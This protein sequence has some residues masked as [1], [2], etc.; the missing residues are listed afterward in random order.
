MRATH[1]VNVIDYENTPATVTISAGDQVRWVN[2]GCLKHNI[3]SGADPVGDG[4]WGLP[5]VAAGASWSRIFNTPGT[6]EHFC[7]LHPTLMPGTVVVTP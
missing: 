5:E 7:S 6:Y 1:T 2:D 3:R 4:A